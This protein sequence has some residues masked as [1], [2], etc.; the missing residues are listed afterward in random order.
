MPASHQPLLQVGLWAA[1]SSPEWGWG[2]SALDWCRGEAGSVAPQRLQ[3]RLPLQISP[4]FTVNKMIN[5]TLAASFAQPPVGQ[6]CQR[7]P[8][9]Y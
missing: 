2:V 4:F 5:M 8:L 9:A 3:P 7:S 6:G 1:L